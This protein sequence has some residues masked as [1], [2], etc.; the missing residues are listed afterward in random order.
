MGDLLPYLHQQPR[1]NCRVEKKR[2]QTGF[3]K[4]PLPEYWIGKKVTAKGLSTVEL[5]RLPNTRPDRSSHA[6]FLFN[7]VSSAH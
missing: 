4:Q 6:A 3:L 1:E 7:K 2:V 5:I